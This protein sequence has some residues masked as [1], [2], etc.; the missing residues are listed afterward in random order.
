MAPK[1]SRNEEFRKPWFFDSF[2]CAVASVLRLEEVHS[3][4]RKRVRLNQWS[5][6]RMTSQMKRRGTVMQEIFAGGGGKPEPPKIPS[7]QIESGH[8]RIQIDDLP[9][10]AERVVSIQ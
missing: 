2:T 4:T 3:H 1:V 9:T 6:V 5:T 8:N 7:R 10:F